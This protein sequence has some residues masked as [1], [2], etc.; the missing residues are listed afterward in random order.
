MKFLLWKCVRCCVIKRLFLIEFARVN[1]L[2]HFYEDK[3]GHFC[4]QRILDEVLAESLDGKRARCT[5]I[6]ARKYS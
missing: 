4:A 6:Y 5:I 2:M 3:E 1:A